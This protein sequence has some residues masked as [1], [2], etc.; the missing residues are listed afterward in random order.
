[1]DASEIPNRN[2][3]SERVLCK[4]CVRTRHEMIY[5]MYETECRTLNK[6]DG[7]KMKAIVMR[8]LKTTKWMCGVTGS[9]EIGDELYT[10][11]RLGSGSISMNNDR[12]R[13]AGFESVEKRGKRNAENRRRND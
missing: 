2:F 4:H 9:G 12:P 13:T 1:M 11:R 5:S 10:T 6:R 7:K 3:E 8:T